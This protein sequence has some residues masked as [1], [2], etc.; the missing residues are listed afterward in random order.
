MVSRLVEAKPDEMRN[1][2]EEAAGISRYKERRKETETRILHTR[3]N[4]ARLNDLREEITKQLDF[5]Q[6]QAK[7]AER[8]KDLRTRE[9]RLEAELL[10]LRLNDLDHA[11]ETGRIDLA[12]RQTEMEAAIAEQRH[13]EAEIVAARERHIV[14][15]EAFNQVQARHY[16]VQSEI[17]RLEQGIAHA[18]EIRERQQLDLAQS[19]EQ[20]AALD[21][22]LARDR[23][24][25]TELEVE[26]AELE[27]ALAAARD[28]EIQALALVQSA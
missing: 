7:T 4:L 24:K 17:S 9:R 15:T 23:M 25:A 14:A 20:I 13:I 26:I 19:Q 6:K 22:D 3:D 21:D 18:R 16:E 5:L 8:Y 28:T 2:I 12:R 1:Y 27:P 11:L 10:A